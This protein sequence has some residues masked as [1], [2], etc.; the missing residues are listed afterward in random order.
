MNLIAT[1][2]EKERNKTVGRIGGNLPCLFLDRESEIEGY[3]FY[4]LFQNP[5]NHEEY[6]S[7]FVPEDYGVMIDNNTYPNCSVKVFFTSFFK[8]K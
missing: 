3:R 8:R 6:F 1:I 2:C 7:I 5:E 4:M